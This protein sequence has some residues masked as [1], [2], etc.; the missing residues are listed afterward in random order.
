MA[1]IVIR[2]LPGAGYLTRSLA[3]WRGLRVGRVLAA[4][5]GIDTVVLQGRVLP[6][7][8]QPLKVCRSLVPAII[9]CSKRMSQ[10]DIDE[11]LYEDLI[12]VLSLGLAI[13][14]KKI[15]QMRISAFEIGQVIKV[16]ARANGM[17]IAEAGGPELGEMAQALMRLTGTSSTP[18]SSVPP[19]GHGTT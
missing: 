7:K 5:T 3:W 2:P 9:R 8:A 17:P 14:Q 15:E 1:S 18:G 16:I 12:L 11:P 10:L 6:V 4:L 19:G 13:P